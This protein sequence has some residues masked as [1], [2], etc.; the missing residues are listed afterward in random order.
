[1]EKRK[2]LLENNCYYHI[3][4][5]SIAKYVV[6][7]DAEEYSRMFDILKL[8]RFSDFNYKYSKFINLE[9]KTQNTII[10]NI[11]TNSP[12]LVEIIAYC[13]M[14]THFHLIL[15][16][17]TNHGISKY[18]ARVLNSYSR[19]F[20]IKHQRI[21]PLWT[22]RFKSVLVSTDKQLLHLT[23]YIHLN[24]TSA[25]LV[26]K[27]EDW[28]FSSYH[29]YLNADTKQEKIC[30][31]DNLFEFSPE[32]YKKFVLDRKSYQ[33]EISHIKNILIDNYTG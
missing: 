18:I 32:K 15:K 7:N 14:P 22:G 28:D 5:R 4:S 24:P 13:I 12:V 9:S 2:E 33:Q 1:M 19:Y 11:E 10:K 25:K 23:R 27:L 30:S 29:E 8:Y 3:F 16:Q 20:N 31:F 21:G 6:F 26:K 17:T